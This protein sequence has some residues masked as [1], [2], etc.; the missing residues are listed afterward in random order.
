[1]CIRDRVS[2][3]STWGDPICTFIFSIIV[4]FTT[5]PIV[6]DC[7]RVLM[8]GTPVNIDVDK[9]SKDIMMNVEGVEDLHDLHVWSLSTGKNALSVHL[10]SQQPYNTLHS[11][12]KLIKN[13]Y[14][15]FHSTI[16]V[17]EKEHA[18]KC[19]NT[20]HQMSIHRLK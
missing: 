19:T 2:T 14:R 6:S 16:Q 17:E 15:I 10:Q 4:I 12:R 11:A 3:Q 9:M 7:L 13:K 1:M 18:Q 5:V 20:L 8:E